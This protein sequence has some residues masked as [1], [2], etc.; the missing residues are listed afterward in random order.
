[1]Q[2]KVSVFSRIWADEKGRYVIVGLW[3]TSFSYGTFAVLVWLL[4][5]H[6]NNSVI[7]LLATLLGLIQS[8][9]CQRLFVWRS[10]KAVRGEL[11]RFA[12]VV[13]GQFLLNLWLLNLAVDRFHLPILISQLAITVVLVVLTFLIL[14]AWTFADRMSRNQPVNVEDM[15]PESSDAQGGLS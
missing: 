3:N 1:M 15:K 4:A 8:Y 12:P 10:T 11:Q 7:L 13:L 5:D 9:W 14:R 2:N 6:M